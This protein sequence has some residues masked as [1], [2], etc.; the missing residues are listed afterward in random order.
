MKIKKFTAKNMQEAM[1]LIKQEFGDDAIILNSKNVKDKEHPE[2]K[3]LIEITAAIDKK[4]S[5]GRDVSP[6]KFSSSLKAVSSELK[7]STSKIDSFQLNLI[8]KDLDFVCERVELLVNHIKYKNLPHI[9]KI[10]QQRVKTLINNGVYQTLA[11]SLIEEVFLNLKGEELLQADLVDD[12]LINKIKTYIQISGPVKLNKNQPAVVAV[13]GSTG[14][15]KTS[16]VAKLAILYKYR[17]SRSVALL[18][19]DNYSITAMDQLKSLAEIAKIDFI[20]VYSN[21]ELVEKMKKLKNYE[22]IFIDTPGINYR[23]MKKMIN[24]KDV[25]RISKADEVHLAISIS[26]KTQDICNTIKNFNT[27]NFSNIIYT[28]LD[29]TEQ[30]GDILNI[31]KDFD[32]P[33]SYLTFGQTVPDD[34]SLADRKEI[35]MTILRGKYGIL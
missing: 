22:I 20:G 12:K 4:E 17:Y 18:S 34:L 7:A 29:E 14:V 28:K 8:Q 35:A 6:P 1:K 2:N 16:T 10:L 31:S 25:L 11:N 26:T 3:N 15:G 19:V 13:I 30:F 32:K 23:D 33:I 5:S 24:L 9:P 21:N 27:V